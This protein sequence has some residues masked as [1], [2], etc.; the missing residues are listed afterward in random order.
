MNFA[1]AYLAIR[2][3]Y[4]IFEFVRHWY[5]KSVRIYW[6]FVLNTLQNLDYFFAWRITVKHLFEPLYKDYSVIG[7]ILGFIFRSLRVAIGSVVYLFVFAIAIGLYLAW[8]LIPPFLIFQ[9]IRG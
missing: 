5:V 3:F 7:Y 6:N 1:P 4:R 9:I 8:L 2:F